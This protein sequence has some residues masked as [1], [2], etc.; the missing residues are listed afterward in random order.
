MK[1]LYRL[2][3]S[4][5]LG[6]ALGASAAI[7]A[8]P[9]EA[10]SVTCQP[11]TA[12][13]TDSFPGT[14]VVADNFESGTLSP[15]S[16][17]TQG[18][19]TAAVSST[20]AHDGACSAYL[21]ATIDA[22]SISN[23]SVPLPSGTTH[24]YAAGWFN[25]TTAGVAGND[26]PYFRFFS[27]ATRIMDIFRYNSTSNFVLRVTAPDGTFSYTTMVGTVA[28]NSWHHIAMDV[29]A[30]GSATAAQVW[31]DDKSVFSSSTLNISATSVSSVMLGSEHP[32]QQADIYV[33]DLIVKNESASASYSFTD[34][35]S[36]YP[37]YKE[38]TWAADAGITTG[39]AM[40][41]QTR[42]FRPLESISREAMAAFI[43]RYMGS[44]AYT[45]PA[46]PKF[47]DY[48]TNSPYYKEVSWLADQGI[49]TGY[50]DGPNGAPTFHPQG[51][52]NRDA[53]AAFIYRLNGSPAVTV[54]SNFID[55]P[56]NYPFYKE[57]TWLANN[58]ITTG[59]ALPDGTSEFR[60]GIAVARDATAAFLYRTNAI[61]PRP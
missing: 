55:V 50:N 33:D 34:V 37:F 59:W 5:I 6:L 42:Q 53:M 2:G 27:G 4:G 1:R 28:L 45:P 3:L 24:A 19:G 60:P 11:G 57:I 58:K 31:F 16:P 13:P 25:I 10:A 56:A 51:T 61:Y 29:T 36:S 32:T 35:T 21:H 43:Y 14:T 40:P 17:V 44:P 46:T 49:T 48:P 26:V 20:M 30:N 22:G 18:T 41:D 54:S 15:Y 8:A 47:A 38:I 52:V 23:M 39:W 12:A 7:V 9:A